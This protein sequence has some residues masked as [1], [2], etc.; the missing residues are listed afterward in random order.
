MA[1]IEFIVD[2]P[3]VSHQT[4]NKKALPAWKATIRAAA[5]S[6]W[7]GMPSKGLLQCTIMN[8]YA[9]P[10]PSLD[11][12]NMVKPIRDAMIGIVYDNDSQ[13]RVSHH[14]QWSN[15]DYFQV[16]GASKIIVDALQQGKEFVYVKIEDAPPKPQLPK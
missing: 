5:A 10:A 15:Q 13:I 3:P 6:L 12:D 4:K 8:F 16:Q 14:A 7:A 1:S 11:D 2:G 9:G